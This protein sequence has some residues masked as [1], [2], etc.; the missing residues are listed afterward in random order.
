VTTAAEST[1]IT[2]AEA[3]VLDGTG[4]FTWFDL[5]TDIL[6]APVVALPAAI[7]EQLGGAPAGPDNTTFVWEPVDEQPATDDAETGDQS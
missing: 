1:G 5:P 4:T 7:Y 3:A 2:E 6:P